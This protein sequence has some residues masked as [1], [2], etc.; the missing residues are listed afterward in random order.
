MWVIVKTSTLLHLLL[1]LEGGQMKSF[2]PLFK[3]TILPIALKNNSGDFWDEIIT[4]YPFYSPI[5]I[6]NLS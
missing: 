3:Y 1:K 4:I 2:L 6:Q 5:F